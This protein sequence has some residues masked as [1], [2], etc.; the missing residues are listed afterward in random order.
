MLGGLHGGTGPTLPQEP[1]RPANDLGF[2]KGRT[3]RV[4]RRA[5][6][7]CGN[8]DVREGPSGGENGGR[9]SAI[10]GKVR[11]PQKEVEGS[12]IDIFRE[13]KMAREG[14]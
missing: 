13:R 6:A 4:G 8:E 7:W 1:L 11:I 10:V 2:G 12:E 14:R 9:E 3:A 5:G